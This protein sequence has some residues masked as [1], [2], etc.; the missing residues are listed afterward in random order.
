MFQHPAY[1]TRRD[2]ASS[3]RSSHMM[4]YFRAGAT[5][6]TGPIVLPLFP[7]EGYKN[8]VDPFPEPSTRS[9]QFHADITENGTARIQ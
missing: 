8:I 2:T 5:W 9:S 4:G 6:P 3:I 7:M 1:E